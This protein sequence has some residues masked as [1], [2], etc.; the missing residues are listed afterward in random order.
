MKRIPAEADWLPASQQWPRCT[1]ER[2]VCPDRTV[3]ADDSSSD[4]ATLAELRARTREA[5]AAPRRPA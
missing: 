3:P 5:N 1:C 2:P 4:S